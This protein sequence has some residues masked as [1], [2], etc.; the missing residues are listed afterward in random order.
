MKT[1]E[2]NAIARSLSRIGYRNVL[3]IQRA[4][5]RNDGTKFA[6]VLQQYQ[7]DVSGQ[8]GSG[9]FTDFTITFQEALYYAPLQR[10][11]KLE[12]PHFTYGYQL[13][14]G[15]AK[16]VAYV[17]NW[18]LDDNAN[19]LGAIVRVHVEQF[20][21]AQLS[22]FSGTVHVTFQGY[23]VPVEDTGYTDTP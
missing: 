5:S 23:G 3:D 8:A 22:K 21:W 1:L 18:T 6:E 2:H 12:D 10:N 17:K 11:L 16:I 13:D 20:E 15:D 7:M 4:Q 19:Y 14:T 9:A